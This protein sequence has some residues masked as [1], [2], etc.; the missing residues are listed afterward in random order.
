LAILADQWLNIPGIPSADI[1]PLPDG[2]GIVNF[3]DFA[4]LSDNWLAD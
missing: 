3:F 2:D 1:A 4:L